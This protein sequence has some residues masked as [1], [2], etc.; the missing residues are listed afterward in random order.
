MLGRAATAALAVLA[1]TCSSPTTP[2]PSVVE[3]VIRSVSPSAGPATGGTELMIRGAGFAAGAAVTIGGQPATDVNVRSSDIIT[4]KTPASPVAAT[5]EVVVAL[6]GRTTALAAAFRYE[7]AAPN[8]APVIKSIAAQGSRP[9]Q[10][11]AFAD[12]GETIRLTLVVEDAESAPAQLTYDWRP[13]DG[14]VSGTGPQVDWTAPA[15]GSLASTCTIEVTVTDGPHVLSRSIV[16]RVH[17]SV[18]EVTA[19][20]MEFLEEFADSSIS[21]ETT[22]R[23]FSDSCK[24]KFDELEEVQRNRREYVH[25]RHDYGDPKTTIAFGGKC[26]TKTVDACVITPVEWQST[27]IPTGQLEVAVGISTITGIYRDSRWWLCDSMA[28]GAS[29]LGFWFFR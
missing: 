28:D 21:A 18:A 1:A 2:G 26:K 6:N 3:L 5:V 20:A 27:Y 22:V 15:V 9:R 16:V 12:Y 11:A 24:G 4:A 14:T 7:P 23:N 29:S 8:T 25:V 10:P 17:N 13:C 19:L